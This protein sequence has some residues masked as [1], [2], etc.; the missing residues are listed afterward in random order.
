MI[1][2]N[3]EKMVTVYQNNKGDEGSGSILRWLRMIAAEMR[4]N[5]GDQSGY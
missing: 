3:E 5:D 2:M 1:A 4:K